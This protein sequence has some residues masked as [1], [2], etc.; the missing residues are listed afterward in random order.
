MTAVTRSCAVRAGIGADG[1]VAGRS[2]FVGIQLNRKSPALCVCALDE[3]RTYTLRKV[4]A[5][6]SLQVHFSSL[7]TEAYGTLVA[8][9]SSI[10]EEDETP[11][12]PEKVPQER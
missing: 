4:R 3:V 8:H 11:A 7:G 5:G 9:L 1:E 12:P 10:H 6:M 2:N